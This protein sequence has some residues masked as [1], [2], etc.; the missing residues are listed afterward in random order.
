MERLYLISY[1]NYATLLDRFV[2]ADGS[3]VIRAQ[4]ERGRALNISVSDEDQ[5]TAAALWEAMDSA[6][7]TAVGVTDSSRFRKLR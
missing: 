4:D 6:I 1:R 7:A 3:L 2:R 5:E